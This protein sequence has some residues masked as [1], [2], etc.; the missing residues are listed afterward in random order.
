MC[1][2]TE[3]D[4]LRTSHFARVVSAV[5]LPHVCQHTPHQRR[6]SNRIF[7]YIFLLQ[8]SRIRKVAY[9]NMKSIR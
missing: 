6:H 4:G 1:H 5:F 8:Y 7:T 3:Y 9:S 2:V